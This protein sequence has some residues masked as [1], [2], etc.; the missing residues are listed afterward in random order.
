MKHLNK[1]IQTLIELRKNEA[2]M[3]TLLAV[4]PNS[5][6]VLEAAVKAATLN[7]TPMLFAATLNQVDI[8]GGYT[9][10]TPA[11]FVR[12]LRAFADA[13]HWHGALYPC[14]DH[15]GPWQ[16]DSHT[17]ER[18]SLEETMQRVKNS[19]A[20][21]IE[22][23]YQLLHIDPTVDRTLPPRQSI[24]VETVVE[25]TIELISFSE[26]ARR[27]RNLPPVAY[28]VGTEEVSGGLA[29]TARFEQFI[30]LLCQGLQ[31][32]GLMHAWPCFIVAQVGTN[33]HT[34][35]FD[36]STARRLYEIVSPLGS[37]VKGH[38]TDWVENPSDYPASGMGGANVGPEFT[39]QEYL[40][41]K[42]L[43][44]KERSLFRYTLGESRPGNQPSHFTLTLQN[45]VISSGRWEKWLQRE[46]RGLDFAAL[47]PA[48]REWLIQTGSRYIWSDPGVQAARQR[49]YKNLKKVLPDPHAYVVDRIV[50]AIDRYINHF[51][52]FDSM[53]IL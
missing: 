30:S 48:R 16:K 7:R 23:G 20:A 35:Y 28:E 43:E 13:Y 25:R 39:I 52:L 33:L 50:S 40:A 4:C 11:G 12:Q 47:S 27:H 5:A 9:G 10:W 14:L 37:M 19:L 34:T 45:A 8:D 22:A 31:A 44:M 17:T 36:P 1:L 18:L 29:E 51:N 15:G 3:I 38:Y 46:E 24:A 41:L 6:A 26:Q 32:N 42:D 53:Q 2:A 21:C 49:L